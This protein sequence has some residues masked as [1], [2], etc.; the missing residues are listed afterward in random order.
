MIEKWQG[1]NMEHLGF[2]SASEALLAID[3]FSLGAQIA[4]AETCRSKE[5]EVPF[6]IFGEDATRLKSDCPHVY[7]YVRATARWCR[8]FLHSVRLQLLEHL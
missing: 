2:G 4:A 6:T 1:Q 7:R 3:F 8:T 5:R